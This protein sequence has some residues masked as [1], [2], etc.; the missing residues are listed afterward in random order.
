MNLGNYHDLYVQSNTLVLADVFESCWNMCIELYEL[1]PAKYL[2][3][4]GL[5]LQEA[6]KKNKV[7]N[8]WNTW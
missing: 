8:I 3:V 7:K 4:P 1:H 5:T 2:P 6:L